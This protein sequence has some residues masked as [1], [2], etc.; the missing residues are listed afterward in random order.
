MSSRVFDLPYRP[1]AEAQGAFGHRH[2][3]DGGP[4]GAFLADL[5]DQIDLWTISLDGDV[6]S[7]D[8][9]ASLLSADEAARASRFRM[10]GDR[11]RFAAGRAGLRRILAAYLRADPASLDFSYGPAGKPEL[12][13]QPSTSGLRFN[14][15]HSEGWALLAV[16]RG[17]AVGVDL[18]RMRA[19]RDLAAIAGRFFAP[20]EA[21]ALA[22]FSPPLH[23]EAFFAIWTRKEALLKAFGA[24]LSLPLDG[25]CVSA[26]P[27]QPAQLISIAC[28]PGEFDR[29]SLLDV[30]LGPPLAQGFRAALAIEGRPRACRHF[31]LGEH[32]VEASTCRGVPPS[33]GC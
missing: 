1:R 2:D 18:E 8:R 20:A 5:G 29:W 24:G 6:T 16:T 7:A 31:R 17:R 4:A 12:A 23:E 27:R 13:G 28:R 19:G 3:H 11:R 9:Q 10:M 33:A 15:S 32:P 25:F 26:D 21:A 22:G 30:L 14:L